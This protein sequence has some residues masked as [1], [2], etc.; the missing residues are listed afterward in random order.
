[1]T[2]Q[3]SRRQL[4]SGN[5]IKLQAAAHKPR[6]MLRVVCITLI[7]A[8]GCA[9]QTENP[10]EITLSFESAKANFA[11]WPS[12]TIENS[13]DTFFRADN[14]TVLLLAGGAS[15]A[16]HEGNADRDI[17]EHFEKHGAFHGFGDESLNLIGHPATHLAAT[18]IYY[19]IS[20]HNQDELHAE[21][22]WTM[23]TALSLTSVTT[24]GLK[25]VRDNEAPNG[26]DWA[27]PSGHASS[28][29]T[30]ASVLDEFYGPKVGVPAYALASLV[31]YRMLDT[32]DHWA[33]D[34]VFGASLGWVVGH[35]FAGKHKQLEIAGFRVLPYA[36]NT[37]SQAVGVTLIKQF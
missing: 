29:F 1:M 21:R 2:Y 9:S 30:V 23:M 33:S 26:K 12:R 13:K 22:A 7:L 6:V 34:V 19:V 35:T 4:L 14:M 37:N 18:G 8:A 24:M 10:S 16:M 32:G 27:W 20:A 28:S 5:S 15:I 11:D 3:V 25:A 17:A 31:S 36:G